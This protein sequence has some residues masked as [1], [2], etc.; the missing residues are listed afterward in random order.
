MALFSDW[1][2]GVFFEG[3]NK[4]QLMIASFNTSSEIKKKK[5][6]RL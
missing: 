6:A 1:R 4:C 3:D 5:K 2:E